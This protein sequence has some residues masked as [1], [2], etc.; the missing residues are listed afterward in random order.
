MFFNT[1]SEKIFLLPYDYLIL[2]KFIDFMADYTAHFCGF[3]AA[4][5]LNWALIL[6][7]SPV[8][9]AIFVGKHL[10]FT[11]IRKYDHSLGMTYVVSRGD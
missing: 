8:F 9:S 11:F 10:E 1:G 6:R 2:A 7:R 3:S 5:L 4:F